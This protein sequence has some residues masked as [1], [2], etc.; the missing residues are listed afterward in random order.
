MQDNDP[1]STRDLVI[2]AAI[3]LFGHQGYEATTVRQIALA[4][5]GQNVALVS[6]Y[7]G[8]KEGL[9]RACAQ[10]I[11]A[12]IHRIFPTAPD[13]M[14]AAG[15]AAAERQLETLL[16]LFL[17][18]MTQVPEAEDLAAFVLRELT[19]SGEVFDI[20]YDGVIADRHRQLCRL[21]GQATGTD[22]ESETTR[23]TAFSMLGQVLYFRIGR[24]VVVRRLG[25]SGIA[26]AET[27][28]IKKILTTNLSAILAAYREDP[29]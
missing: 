1:Q 22:P 24:P 18:F 23:L 26:P 6:Y 29:E 2:A 17:D 13:E 8:S 25:W 14:P 3:R 7:F 20:L 16:S 10:E 15:Q 27:E 5:G 9:R 19:E 28:Q 21:W 4:A 12:R 11:V